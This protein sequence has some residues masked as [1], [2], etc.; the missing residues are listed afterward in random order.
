MQ[1]LHISRVAFGY[2]AM[3]RASRGPRRERGAPAETR[4]GEPE[5]TE[6]ARHQPD[7]VDHTAPLCSAVSSFGGPSPWGRQ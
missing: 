4:G 5:G 2:V 3:L 1:T 6:S 7:Q